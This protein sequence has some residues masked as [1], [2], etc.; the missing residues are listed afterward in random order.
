MD[1]RKKVITDAQKP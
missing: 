1:H